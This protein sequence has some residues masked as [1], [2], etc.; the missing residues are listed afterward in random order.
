MQLYVDSCVKDIKTNTLKGNSYSLNFI[1]HTEVVISEIQ[2][3]INE[4]VHRDEISQLITRID[5]V[6]KFIDKFTLETNLKYE[7]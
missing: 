4:R 7:K 3:I 5:E 2:K 6:E 1:E